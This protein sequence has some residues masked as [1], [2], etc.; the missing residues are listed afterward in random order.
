MQE[1]WDPGFHVTPPPSQFSAGGPPPRDSVGGKEGP[2]YDWLLKT[3]DT[4]VP[5]TNAEGRT[6]YVPTRRDLLRALWTTL[7][8]PIAS[9]RTL[10]SMTD[11][12]TNQKGQSDD[13]P[14][15]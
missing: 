6:V 8:G 13:C 15:G 9:A 11:F 12:T 2:A 5:V 14:A 4:L 10:F 3:T 1:S 7:A